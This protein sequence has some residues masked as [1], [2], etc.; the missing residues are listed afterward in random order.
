MFEAMKGNPSVTKQAFTD[1]WGTFYSGYAPIYH[2]GTAMGIVAVDYEAS[3]IRVSLNSL[4]RN[5]LIAVTIGILFA[6]IAAIFVAI[7]MKRNFIK[8]NN[9]ILEVVS[10]EGDL[11]KILDIS[12]GDEL[13]VIGNSLNQLLQKTGKT[14]KQIKNEARNIESKMENI[15]T[16][17]S[18][19]VSQITNIRDTIQSMVAASETIAGSAGVVG[20]QVNLV[21]KDIQKIVGIVTQNTMSLRD[22]SHS[23]T[24]LNDTAQHSFEMIEEQ[25]VEMSQRLQKEKEKAA[26]VLMIKELSD[27]ILNI[28]G[29]TNLLALNASIEAARAGDA[30]MGFAVVAKEIG[31]LAGR[32]NQA[33]NEIQQMS[34]DVVEAIQGLD[35]LA[36]KMLLLLQDKISTDYQQF[37][38]TSQ[39]FTDKSNDMKGTME[40]LQ[41]I[42]QK[43]AESLGHMNNAMMSVSA[44]SEE[45]SAEIV[46]VSELLYSIDAD[47]KNIQRSTEETL[48]AVLLMNHDLDSYQVSTDT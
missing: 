42:T 30:G 27:T 9:K 22:I 46:K 6:V 13:E 25:A 41:Q 31:V 5:I 32:T 1:E 23:S 26:A 3:S 21:H 8:V 18:D 4:I 40:Q 48:S 38:A 2:N 45:N 28:S 37:G 20:E 24:Q 14:I 15:N 44:S 11:T 29:R 47:M 39:N 17:V 12:S 16:H 34:K 19:S 35:G 7:R 33:V 10:A 43:Y 36:D